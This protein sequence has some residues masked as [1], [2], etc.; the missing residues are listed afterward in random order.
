MTEENLKQIINNLHVWKDNKNYFLSITGQVFCVHRLIS[1]NNLK[2]IIHLNS[3][4]FQMRGI[5][6]VDAEPMYD[7]R[8][9]SRYRQV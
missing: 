8:C 6:H 2:S 5:L 4:Y 7:R 9:E 3:I 1:Y